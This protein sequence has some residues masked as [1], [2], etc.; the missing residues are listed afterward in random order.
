MMMINTQNIPDG[1]QPGL[2]MIAP[3]APHQD[4][5]DKYNIGDQTSKIRERDNITIG[6]WNVRT[7]RPAGKLKELTFE[8][9]RYRWNLLELCEVRWKN[10]GETTTEEGHKLYYSSKEY[11]HEYGVGFLVHKNIMKS[12]MG[13]RPISIRLRA[14]PFN[15][16]VIQAYAPTTDNNDD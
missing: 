11:K 8:M 15:I 10:F 3:S 5:R 14:D 1:S 4:I 16:T 13:C 6:T 2:T 7:M 12:A 9:D